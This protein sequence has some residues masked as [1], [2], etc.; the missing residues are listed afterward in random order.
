MACR[1]AISGRY[2][3]KAAAARHPR[4]SISTSPTCG[5]VT[6]HGRASSDHYVDPATSAPLHHRREPAAIAEGL[7]DSAHP[8][9]Y[10]QRITL[11]C[12]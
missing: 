11:R 3:R 8:T 2:T 5:S 6:R 9:A 7:A 1:S 10:A 4:T 12:V